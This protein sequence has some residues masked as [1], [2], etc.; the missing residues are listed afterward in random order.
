[1]KK[2]KFEL[3][4]LHDIKKKEEDFEKK[5]MK[6][7]EERLVKLHEGLEGLH[8]KM[9]NVKSE[10]KEEMLGS[11]KAHNLHHY[12]NYMKKIKI[13]INRQKEK[14]VYE[15]HQKQECVNRLVELQ[16]ELKSLEKLYEQKY[17]EYLQETKKE[18]EKIIDD[19]VSF[20]IAAS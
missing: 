17:E 9:E 13:E 15:T 10:L 4:T 1:M 3:Q 18:Q 6:S 14:I 20:N 19:I 2:F 11:V 12:D 16:K 5:H 7:I 8:A